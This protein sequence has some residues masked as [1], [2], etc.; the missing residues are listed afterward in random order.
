VPEVLVDKD[1]F[2]IVRKRPTFEE[3]VAGESLPP[4]LD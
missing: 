1:R 4:W 2:A 3:M